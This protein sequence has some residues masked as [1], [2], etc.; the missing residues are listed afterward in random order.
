MDAAYN[1]ITVYQGVRAKKSH[2]KTV[3]PRWFYSAPYGVPRM[4]NILEIRE[5]AQSAWARICIDTL[6]DEVTTV[7]WD[8]I[9][10]DPKMADNPITQEHIEIVRRF[11]EKPNL[12]DE[13]FEHILRQ[14]VRD[15]LE[16][17]AGVI[18]K[19][20][21][22]HGVLRE[23]YAADGATFLKEV[24]EHGVVQGYYQYS[25]RSPTREPIWFDE[26][27]IV[28]IMQ[29]PRSYSVYGF[30]PAQSILSILKTLIASME[31]NEKYFTDAAIPSG[32]ISLLDISP[33]EFQRFV[34]YWETEVKGN[35]HKM[36]IVNT[37]VK[38]QAFTLS[39]KDMQ[40]LESQQ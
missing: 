38:W 31:W 25:W 23:I 34:S 32:I 30:S 5:F 33:E 12:N 28:Y 20:F 2:R 37:D 13:S 17:D 26:R 6:I 4:V 21:D 11:F 36:P 9:P 18:V 10:K 14:V 24:D 27:E 15:I 22:E 40:F 35:P 39:N 19:V 7:D 16:I 1:N 3:V 29:N 8:I